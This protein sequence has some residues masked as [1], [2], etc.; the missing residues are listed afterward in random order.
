MT[1]VASD[2]QA[3]SSVAQINRVGLT[4][5]ACQGVQQLFAPT[6]LWV[7]WFNLI[8]CQLS[9]DKMVEACLPFNVNATDALSCGV[10]CSDYNVSGYHHDIVYW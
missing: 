10:V 3:L 4:T 1:V 8:T 9:D 7:A 2:I 6:T 5:W